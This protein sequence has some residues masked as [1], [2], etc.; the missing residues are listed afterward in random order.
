[1]KLLDSSRKVRPTIIPASLFQPC[2]VNSSCHVVLTSEDR[3]NGLVN[4]L[5]LAVLEQVG[6]EE[7]DDEECD[8]DE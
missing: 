2:I 6:G 8:E 3:E 7:S 1:M 5:D 4:D